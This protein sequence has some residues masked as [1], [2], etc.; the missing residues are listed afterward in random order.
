MEVRLVHHVPPTTASWR[1]VWV[2]L[3][4]L[5]LVLMPSTASA[6]NRANRG[7]VYDSSDG[8]CV[9]NDTTLVHNWDYAP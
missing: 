3:V 6:D 9:Y 1:P 4:G 2:T 8:L 7:W 5:A